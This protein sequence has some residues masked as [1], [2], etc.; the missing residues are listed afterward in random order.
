M[1]HPNFDFVLLAVFS[2]MVVM[3]LVLFA[4]YYPGMFVV[5]TVTYAVYLVKHFFDVN[6]EKEEDK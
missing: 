2:L 4:Y 1:N 3:S 6:I 5:M